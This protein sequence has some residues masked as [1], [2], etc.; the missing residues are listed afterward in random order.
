MNTKKKIMLLSLL[1]VGFKTGL[2]DHDDKDHSYLGNTARTAAEGAGEA[3]EGFGTLLTAPVRGAV[4][5][6][7]E[8]KE[9]K[10]NKKKKSKK[11]KKKSCC[12]KKNKQNKTEMMREDSN[13]DEPNS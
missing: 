9:E 12:P 5:S 7:E 11:S 10:K 13:S 6:S 1:L 3:V 4:K 2:A 8:E